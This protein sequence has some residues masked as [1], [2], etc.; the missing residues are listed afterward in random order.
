[1]RDALRWILK[2]RLLRLEAIN[3]II[4][5]NRIENQDELSAR[6]RAE[7]F[8]VA[9]STLSRDLKLLK[10][11][12]ASVGDGGYVY[13][14]SKQEGDAPAESVLAG[15]FRRGCV[16]I[17]F[18]GNIAVIKTIEGHGSSVAASLDAMEVDGVLG[19][20]AGENCVFAC[21]KEGVG[22]DDF[23]R[24]LRKRVPLLKLSAR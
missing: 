1:M 19:T 21:L 11:G 15:D 9:Q 3:A 18:S 24:A 6:L 2:D 8:D 22:K 17:E 16:G 13:A 12:K 23:M 14:I 7:G 5:G 10:V 20:I 4:K